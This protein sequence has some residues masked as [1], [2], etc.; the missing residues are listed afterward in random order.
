MGSQRRA[1]AGK[2]SNRA[3]MVFRGGLR[4]A[5]G[6]CQRFA[7][8]RDLAVVFDLLAAGLQHPAPDAICCTFEFKCLVEEAAS[9]SEAFFLPQLTNV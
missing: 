4:T 3:R 8:Y 9:N 1:Y 2:E 5:S 7:S 6:G